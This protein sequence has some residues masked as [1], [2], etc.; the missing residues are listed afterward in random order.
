MDDYPGVSNKDPGNE[1]DKAHDRVDRVI[2]DLT[3]NQISRPKVEALSRAV[4]RAKSHGGVFK[5]IGG[6]GG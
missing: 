3:N 1:I 4:E 2:D 5:A 6:I